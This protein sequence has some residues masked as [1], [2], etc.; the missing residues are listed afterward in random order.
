MGSC[1]KF[2]AGRQ[3]QRQRT[4]IRG[5]AKLA[6]FKPSPGSRSS[7]EKGEG[8]SVTRLEWMFGVFAAI[9]IAALVWTVILG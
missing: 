2:D 4:T 8:S 3:R 5:R 1:V 7:S 9:A 6:R